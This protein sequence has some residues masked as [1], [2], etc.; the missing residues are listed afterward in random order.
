MVVF[1]REPVDIKKLDPLVIY[2][3]NIPGEEGA[4]IKKLRYRDKTG[5][6][7]LIPI[8]VNHTIQTYKARDARVLGVAVGKAWEKI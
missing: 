8:N 7:D 1:N 3:I 4:T 5:E 6:L 2:V